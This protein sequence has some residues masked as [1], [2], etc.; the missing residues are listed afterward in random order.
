MIHVRRNQA[1]MNER[2]L[3]RARKA[4]ELC[5][6]MESPKARAK[7]IRKCSGI[8]KNFRDALLEMSHN[9]CWYSEASEAVSDWHV[10][11]FRPKSSYQWL[12]FDWHNLR[13]SGAIPNRSKSDEFPL[14]NGSLRA[15]W[16]NRDYARE[17]YL[18]LDPTNPNDPALMTFDERGVPIPVDPSWPLVKERVEVTTKT[19]EL[20]SAR[21]KDARQRHWRQCKDWIDELRAL[22]PMDQADI[23]LAR[24]QQIDRIM[25]N[26]RR[27]TLPGQPYSAV[28]K[29]CLR[30]DGL[31]FLIAGA[32][33]QEAA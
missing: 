11:H 6:K 1:L 32:E 5:E 33:Y 26:L 19:L 27:M 3:E 21:L 22:L 4:L 28:A 30:A 9:K 7:F 16:E 29:A 10:D 13:I 8:W 24:R 17:R 31:D 20:D 12:A 2:W 23:D 14:A 25:N 18:L 15:E